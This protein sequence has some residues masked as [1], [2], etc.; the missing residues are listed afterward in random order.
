MYGGVFLLVGLILAGGY[1]LVVINELKHKLSQAQVNK[2]AIQLDQ[3]VLEADTVVDRSLLQT[4]LLLSEG[5]KNQLGE[6]ASTKKVE[7]RK[8]TVA[9]KKEV[10]LP[11]LERN[12]CQKFNCIQVRKEFAEIPS[13]IWKALLGTED[14]RFLEHKGV[15]PIAIARAIVVDLIAMKFIQ[16]G[17]TL[18]QQ[19]MKN[20]F[21]TNDRKLSRKL[22]EV[23]Y[24]V[25]IE[26]VMDKEQIL[27]LYLNEMFW[28]VFQGV[29][30]KGFYAASLVY[31]DKKPQELSDFEA[32]IL[33]SLLKGPGFY[34]PLKKIER[35]QTRAKAVY[36][37][38]MKLNLVI[39]SEDLIWNEE[40]W[41][42]YQQDLIQRDSEGGFRIYY[43]AS[44]NGDALLEGFEKFAL[45]KSI[46]HHKKRLEERFPDT[47]LAIKIFMAN[48]NCEGFDCRE[49]FSYYSKLEREKRKGITA[50]FHQVGSLYK[51]IVYDTFVSLGRDYNEEVSTKPL[52]LKLKS[53]SWSP[54]DYSKAK[55]EI[56]SLKVAL[57]K[58]K[59]IPLIRVASELGFDVLER[60]LTS[61]I[62]RLQT[63]LGEFPAQLLGSIELSLEEVFQSYNKFLADKCE[64]V[65]SGSKAFES[66]IL[67]YMS[68]AGETTI[69]K[70]ARAP[71]KNAFVF[72]K[73]GT[74]NNGLDNWY[75]AYDGAQIYVFW[76][77]VETKRNETDLRVSGATSSFLIFQ[78]FMNR[79]GKQVAEVHCHRGQ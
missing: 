66:S 67:F 59:N 50:E 39:G 47:D 4:Y 17:S 30:I 78:D 27:T 52:T 18:T 5:S 19:L 65:S 15:D 34:N 72:G 26:H 37:R 77:G 51:P 73:T 33:I 64:E 45:Y 23:V 74:S 60:E 2:T 41:S 13:S 32:T 58:S 69:A 12:S 56:I 9:V 11:A 55:T 68:L 3:S 38:L 31:F 8:T 40:T 25:Y 21:L 49:S 7:I 44:K 63:P 48:T 1:S 62:P 42:Q 70:L 79:R 28:G 24:A 53:G 6:L 22:K 14:F 10:K 29:Y 16:G 75:F 46:T 20:L 43:L 71:L 61:R 36:N 76:F 35:I 54:K 57:Q